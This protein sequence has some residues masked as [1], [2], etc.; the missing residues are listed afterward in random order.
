MTNLIVRANGVLPAFMQEMGHYHKRAEEL[1]QK[2][3]SL[4]NT[5]CSLFVKEDGRILFHLLVDIGSGVMESLLKYEYTK[6]LK[7]PEYKLRPPDSLLV[8]HPHPDHCIELYILVEGLKRRRPQVHYKDWRLPIIGTPRCL[9]ALTERFYWLKPHLEIR[10]VNFGQSL[11]VATEGAGTISLTPIEVCHAE[12]APGSAI[13][14]LEYND[15]KILF[16]WDFLSIKGNTNNLMEKTDV[17]FLDGNTWNRHPETGHISI[18]EGLELIKTWQPLR[19]FFVHYSG[20]EDQDDEQKGL[21]GP[22]TTEEL[23]TKIGKITS[24]WGWSTDRIKMARPEMEV[25]LK[26]NQNP[27]IFSP[28][29]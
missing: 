4:V 7:T 8:T 9:N 24:A 16:G 15:R 21:P 25:H 11:E 23:E 10:T 29:A 12:H 18:T 13:Y 2:S 19:T 5:S 28:I 17:V 27:Q 26:E 20:Y 14:L 1:A 6:R 3:W 22:M